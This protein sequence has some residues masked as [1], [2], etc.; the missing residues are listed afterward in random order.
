MP[1]SA[2][3]G[4]AA[5]DGQALHGAQVEEAAG[6]CEVARRRGGECGAGGH[7]A[8]V[9]RGH[10]RAGAVRAQCGAARAAGVALPQGWVEMG[11]GG[12]RLAAEDLDSV[13]STA[14]KSSVAFA[15]APRHTT[16]GPPP[17]GT[18]FS[19]R[20]ET[21]GCARTACRSCVRCSMPPST[22][23]TVPARA[24]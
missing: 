23:P 13:L 18:R 9:R 15:R 11:R 3:T 17:T 5:S 10:R 21:G 1:R 4:T 24:A 12:Q 19:C 20:T 8:G 16:L 2:L 22:A 6:R 14:P 7:A